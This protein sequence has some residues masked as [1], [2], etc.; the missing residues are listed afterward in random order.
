MVLPPPV[1]INIR[2]E[3]MLL[4][5]ELV[6][7]DAVPCSGPGT[8]KD[9]DRAS[10]VGLA[11]WTGTGPS[12]HWDPPAHRECIPSASA[13]PQGALG[14]CCQGCPTIHRARPWN[15]HSI[16]EWFGWEGP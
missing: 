8:S 15:H 16:R 11:A 2:L 4:S 3:L 9:R 6:P 7:R 10:R 13:V 14:P 5:E 1:R 12:P